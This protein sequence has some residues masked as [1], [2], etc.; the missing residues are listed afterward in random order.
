MAV[1]RYRVT[2]S[3]RVQGVWYRESC[4]REARAAEVAGWVRNNP[5]GTV[6][7]VLEGDT[8]AV[9]RVVRWMRDG[10]RHA[11]VTG[12]EVRAEAP[13]GEQTFAVR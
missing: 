3:G 1:V 6:E 4:R 8:A 13:E 7:A 10:P 2:V 11:V 12:V 5:D 9:E